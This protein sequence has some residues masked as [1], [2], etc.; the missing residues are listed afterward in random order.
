MRINIYAVALK[1]VRVFNRINVY[2]SRCLLS[3]K[4]LEI[5]GVIETIN[6]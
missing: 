6:I 3:L 5:L 1:K 4:T 2:R